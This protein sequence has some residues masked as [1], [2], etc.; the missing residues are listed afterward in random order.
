MIFWRCQS[1]PLLIQ[2][3]CCVSEHF[4]ARVSA[5]LHRFRASQLRFQASQ[6]LQSITTSPQ[7]ITIT[8]EH[9]NLASEHLNSF[10]TSQ[11]ATSNFVSEQHRFQTPLLP[12]QL[13]FQASINTSECSN[14]IGSN[15]WFYGMV[16]RWCVWNKSTLICMVSELS[17]DKMGNAKWCQICLQDHV[18]PRTHVYLDIACY[19]E[20]MADALGFP[21][22]EEC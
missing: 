6:P 2:R 9:H 11:S 1:S 14:N 20:D 10:R 7:S 8:S 3:T 13:R 15:Q 12:Q 4:I 19:H 18:L 5:Q 22:K 16:Q 17:S 21:Q